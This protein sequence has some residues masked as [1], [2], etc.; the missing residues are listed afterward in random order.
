LPNDPQEL[1]K[2]C[3]ALPEDKETTAS[4]VICNDL[5]TA[6]NT[7]TNP[8]PPARASSVDAAVPKHDK[9]DVRPKQLAT[10]VAQNI[11]TKVRE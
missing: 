4:N 9:R 8:Y 3:N 7:S 5:R 2:L 11:Q 6:L 1:L 10:V